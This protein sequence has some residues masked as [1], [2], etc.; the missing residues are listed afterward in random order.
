MERIYTIPLREAFTAPRT[1]RASKA[2]KV[3]RGFLERHMKT[4]DVK[5]DESINEVLWNCGREKPP[6]RIKVKV[7][8]ED[9]SE[10]ATATL[11]EDKE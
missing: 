6:R 2:I 10:R 4:T 7:V 3:V 5:L 1:R 9:E 8:K 11:V